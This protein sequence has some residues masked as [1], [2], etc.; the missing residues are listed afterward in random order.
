MLYDLWLL[1]WLFLDVLGP[2]LLIIF[3]LRM[4]YSCLV[5][6]IYAVRRLRV[7]DRGDVDG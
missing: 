2:I 3:G 5:F 4:A 1:L 6:L 7:L